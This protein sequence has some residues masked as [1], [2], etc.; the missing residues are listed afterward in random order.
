MIA[1]KAPDRLIPVA[2]TSRKKSRRNKKRQAPVDPLIRAVEIGKRFLVR[3][4][5]SKTSI[6]YRE[7]TRL[8]SD[9]SNDE[10]PDEVWD[11]GGTSSRRPLAEASMKSSSGRPSNDDNST[12]VTMKKT[13]RET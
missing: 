7:K 3:N 6:N 2:S 13:A 9:S 10:M 1:Y 5:Q 8:S 11:E 12:S 4:A